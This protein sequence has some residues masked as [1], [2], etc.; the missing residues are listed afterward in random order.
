MYLLVK[1]KRAKESYES[2]RI[3]LKKIKSAIS[4]RTSKFGSYR[5]QVSQKDNY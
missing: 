1:S 4:H 3:L 5:Q 2:Q